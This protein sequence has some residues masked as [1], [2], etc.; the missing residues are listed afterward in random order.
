MTEDTIKEGDWVI[1]RR[2]HDAADERLVQVAPKERSRFAKL[3]FRTFPLVGQP[4]GG[5]FKYVAAE[6][7]HFIPA[8]QEEVAKEKCI[9]DLLIKL[10][11]DGDEPST[12]TETSEDQLTGETR[13]NR[14]LLDDQTA[15][16]LT[17]KDIAALKTLLLQ[18]GGDKNAE[19]AS[20]VIK[21]LVNNSKTF[22][23]KTVF[24]QAK[25][26]AKKQKKFS[27]LFV[28]VKPTVRRMAEMLYEADLTRCGFMRYDTLA[29]LLE[30]G[31]IMSGGRYAVI[32][33]SW[34]L[35]SA[36]VLDRLGPSGL[37]V[38]I[39]DTTL[40]T[41]RRCVNTLNLPR[42][43]VDQLLVSV[44]FDQVMSHMSTC[45]T[46]PKNGIEEKSEPMDESNIE[47]KTENLESK[48]ASDPKQ[49]AYRERKA[50]RERER[51]RA[52]SALEAKDLDGLII[53]NRDI[54]PV[55]L[56]TYFIDFISTSK[57]FVI[58]NTTLEPL[59][60]CFD[61]IKSQA[62]LLNIS[63][64]WCRKQQV[65]P[66]RTHPHVNMSQS[67]GYLLTGIKVDP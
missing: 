3:Q 64:T 13:D 2:F 51:S 22:A 21:E 19:G 11:N 18:N 62:V 9:D 23:G 45:R 33:T 35:V 44:S 17:P 59:V 65:L 29:Q 7:G 46:E 50:Q 53:A 24:S 28:V 15:Q 52:L 48:P 31:N 42:D 20:L 27:L 60:Q 47:I 40:Q 6:G 38:Q 36:A 14:N 55:Q 58:F 66:D 37:C 49:E 56:L 43:R 32:D 10:R 26:L 57:P 5:T 67:S 34:G 39:V 41:Y 30:Y 63:E 1:V 25:Y 54:D 4:Y 12:E 8:T 16:P 61:S